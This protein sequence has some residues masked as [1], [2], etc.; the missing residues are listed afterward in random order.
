MYRWRLYGN[1][2][3]FFI[4]LGFAI[5]SYNYEIYYTEVIN[6]RFVVKDTIHN[7]LQC[8]VVAS[9]LISSKFL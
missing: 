7:I 9:S 6:M 8:V 3:A 2:A 1:L 4:L 5:A